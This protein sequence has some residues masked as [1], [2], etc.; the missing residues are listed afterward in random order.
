[1]TVMP[2]L[3]RDWLYRR[4]LA[5]EETPLGRFRV[6]LAHTVED[7]EG[8]FRLVQAAYVARGIENV[9][10]STLRITPQHVL[11]EAYVLIA[12]EGTKLVGT[13]TVT[14][15]SPALLP[16]DKDYPAELQGLRDA[17]ERMCEFGSLAVVERCRNSG[18]TT[19]M[20]MAALTIASQTLRA[21]RVVIGVN[22]GAVAHHRATYAFRLLGESKNHAQLVAP[23]R[24][25]VMD[26]D[27]LEGFLRKKF[28]KP[29]RD[30]TPFAAACFGATLSCIDL[31]RGSHRELIR[32]KLSREVFQELFLRRSDRLESL[33][34]RTQR[35]LEAFRTPR[36]MSKFPLRNPLRQSAVQN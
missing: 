36:T 14:L 23:V 4:K 27:A 18:V 32:W 6:R 16:L 31:P 30:G 24:G 19:L 21:S 29:L 22:P 33:D 17:G 25:M 5:I 20:N 2:E 26:L 7:Y 34:E 3:I 11:P 15:D 9:F 8:A 28:T 1:M 10:A 13:M 12:E 35:H